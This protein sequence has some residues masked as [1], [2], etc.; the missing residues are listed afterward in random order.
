MPALENLDLSN[1]KLADKACLLALKQYPNLLTLKFEG[2]PFADELA[3][4]IKSEILVE[5]PELTKLKM[6][7][8]DEVTEED[9]QA[10]K[11]TREERRKAKEEAE[12]E[13]REAAE[14]AKNEVVDE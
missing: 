3:D 9:V 2:C 12:R 5:V 14:A 8:E 4:A 10:A 6:V 11:E 1:N 13:A 7:G